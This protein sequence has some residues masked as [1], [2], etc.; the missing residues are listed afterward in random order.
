M[1]IYDGLHKVSIRQRCPAP[2]RMSESEFPVSGALATK[3]SLLCPKPRGKGILETDF[4][5]LRD[6]S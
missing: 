2:R 4:Q 1:P 5:P 6:F 3:K